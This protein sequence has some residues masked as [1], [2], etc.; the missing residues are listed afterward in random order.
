MSEGIDFESLGN[1]RFLVSGELDLATA[2]EALDESERLFEPFQELDLDF[3]HIAKTDSAGLAVLIEWI[4][5]ARSDG[6]EIY[7]RNV[8]RQVR[9]LAEISEVQSML[10]IVDG[11]GGGVA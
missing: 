11:Q 3:T 2:E 10:P 8:P 4:S 1:G 9:L 5:R 7:F 6:K